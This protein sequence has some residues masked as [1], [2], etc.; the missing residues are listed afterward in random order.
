MFELDLEETLPVELTTTRVCLQNIR[1]L[2]AMR[3]ASLEHSNH[4]HFPE[5]R[6][7]LRAAFS[8]PA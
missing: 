1:L 7:D 5:I 2:P 3:D 4:F 6:R 8:L